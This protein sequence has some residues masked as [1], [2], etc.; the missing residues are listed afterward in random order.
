V[1]NGEVKDLALSRHTVADDI[2]ESF[3]V[4]A[5]VAM[6]QYLREKGSLC[7]RRVVRTPKRWDGIQIIAA[8]F[9]ARLP[10]TPDPRALSEFLDQRKAADPTHFPDLSLSVVKLLGP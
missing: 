5:N 7:I 3:M 10:P 8:K 1:Q 4:S 6:A 9:G 2:I